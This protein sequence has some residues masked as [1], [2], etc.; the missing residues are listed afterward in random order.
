MAGD[1]ADEPEWGVC[2]DFER[3]HW[4]TA[5]RAAAGGGAWVPRN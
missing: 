4:K 1:G 2:W 5:G 3:S